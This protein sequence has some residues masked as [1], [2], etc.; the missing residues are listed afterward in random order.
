MKI[1]KK[2]EKVKTFTN[3]STVAIGNF[4]GVHLGHRKVIVRAKQ[5][6][7]SNKFGIITFEPHPRDYF[8]SNSNPFKLTRPEKKYNML[9]ELGVDF[10]VELKF[11][12]QLEKYS[13]EQFV[14]KILFKN[15]GVKN[16]IVGQDFQF[17]YKRSGDFKKLKDLG[18]N[19]GINAYAIELKNSRKKTISSTLIRKALENGKIKEAKDMLGY[20]HRI[21]GEVVRGEQRGRE[22]GFPTVNLEFK[23]ILIPRFGVYSCMIEIL[24]KKFNE[25]YKGVASIGERPTFGKY[26]ANLEVHIFDFDHQI[27][28]EEIVVS[29]IN[30]Q[31]P[32]EKF[33][34]IE[35]LIKQMK[36]DSELARNGISSHRLNE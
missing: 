33:G 4:D 2:L 18:K 19:F 20:W 23:K 30:F 14:S 10:V 32:E 31:R 8:L 35:Q 6:A 34:N 25:V 5:L 3:Q 26:E 36:I 9:K 21:Y 28:G 1:L 13:P 15:L 16:V 12:Q 22:L 24:S 27:Y 29:L 11:N 17:G 7:E